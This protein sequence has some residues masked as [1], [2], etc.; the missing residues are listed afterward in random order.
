LLDTYTVSL[1]TTN[2][3]TATF[4]IAVTP[5]DGNTL[6]SFYG[7][8]DGGNPSY[9]AVRLFIQAN[10]PNDHSSKCTAYG[11]GNGLTGTKN[12]NNYWWADDAQY[13]FNPVSPTAGTVTLTAPLG[14]PWSDICGNSNFGLTGPT[15]G[16][17]SALSHIKYVGLS[18]GSGSFYSNGL[19]VDGTTG[20]A[21]FTLTSFTI[22]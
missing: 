18:F 15:T 2:T 19:G 8:P 22:T 17:L 10:L 20:T 9:S 3:I 13:T 1:T 12:T 4:T 16:F 21:T 6:V 5:S 7:N 11:N 14:S